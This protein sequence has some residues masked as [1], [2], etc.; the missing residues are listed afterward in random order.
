MD[1]MLEKEFIKTFGEDGT[2]IDCSCYYHN[3]SVYDFTYHLKGILEIDISHFSVI[4]DII[5]FEDEGIPE[6]LK[7]RIEPKILNNVVL[8]YH[9]EERCLS[10]RPRKS[11]LTIYPVDN[12][13]ASW[14]NL[15]G[16]VGNYIAEL[17]RKGG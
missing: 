9:L 16:I 3:S 12:E 8:V 7:K 13:K 15:L 2:D 1:R 14:F 17:I 4:G 5:E 6:T 10:F 11:G